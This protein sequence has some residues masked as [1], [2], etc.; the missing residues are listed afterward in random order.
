MDKFW[1]I[2]KSWRIDWEIFRVLE[3]IRKPLFELSEQLLI[4]GVFAYLHFNGP[5]NYVIDV[6]YYL[7]MGLWPVALL[8]RLGA[9]F[10]SLSDSK[11]TK[12]INTGTIFTMV[13]YF[14][15]LFVTGLFI[16][17]YLRDTVKIIGK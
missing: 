9:F 12:K 11:K 7:M 1:S 13:I 6:I 17:R 16:L 14:L 4:T 15:I 3:I 2:L 5:K 8:S 10:L